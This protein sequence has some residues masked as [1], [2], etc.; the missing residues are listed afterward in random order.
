MTQTVHTG[1]A[2]A[3]ITRRSFGLGGLAALATPAILSATAFPTM[4]QVMTSAAPAMFDA[5]LGRYRITSLFDG[6]GPLQKGMFFGDAAAIDATLAAAGIE[7]DGLP[8]PINAFLLQ[9]DDR[10][11]LIDAGIGDLEFFGPGLGR[12]SDGLAAAGVAPED[13]DTVIITHAHGDHIGGLLSGG[14]AAFP[15]AETFILEAEQG[16]WGD[17]GIMAQAP[18]EAQGAF[19]LA[20]AV[21]G[22]YGDRLRPVASGTEVAPGV[23]LELSAGHTPGH[24]LV[25]IDGGDRELLM[26]ADTLHSSVLHTALPDVGFGFD[27][28]AEQAAASRRRVFDRAATDNMLIAATH[29][30]FPGFGRFVRAGDAYRYVPASWL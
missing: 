26:V 23:T 18:E 22:A 1:T 27:T 2:N 11:I 14:G 24:A 5:P 4:A 10:T 9:S 20:Q 13:V 29:V 3:K 7:G 25:H 15:N 19:Q 16:F 17:A 6:M 8:T 21:F 30:A 12:V 28:D